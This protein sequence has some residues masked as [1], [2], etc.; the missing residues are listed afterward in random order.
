MRL[1]KK[2]AL[3]TGGAS[4]IG[5]A[6]A[7]R[8][9]Q[10]GAYV[11][12]CD[13]DKESLDRSVAELNP[14]SKRCIG[15]QLD[16]TSS[17]QIQACV[18]AV[19]EQWGGIDILINNAGITKDAQ[20]LKMTEA[21]WD[22]VIDVNLK[23][24]FQLGKA[25]AP[26]MVQAGKGVILNAS[27]VVGIY[28]NFG[29]SNYS[30]TKFGVIGLTKTW[31]RELGPKGVRVNAVCPGFIETPILKSIPEKVLKQLEATSWQ[32]RLGQPSE[33]ASVYAFLA[34]DDAAFVNGACIEVSGGISL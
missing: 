18:S 5:F 9:L 23:A 33:V 2:I 17:E 29:Q 21:Q 31:A 12:V 14:A 16:V 28:G 7:Q 30:A 8:L 10:E 34:S 13:K 32:R 20:L 26:L 19:V 6:T 1:E 15:I 27:S 22:D 11:A 24:V 4:G 25:V 3:V